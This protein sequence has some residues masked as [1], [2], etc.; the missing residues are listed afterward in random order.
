MN[1]TTYSSPVP[2]QLIPSD[3]RMKM[4][5]YHD[6]FKLY[7]T[8]IYLPDVKLHCNCGCFSG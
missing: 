7:S 8:T 3:T 1:G 6:L 4:L 2:I 5:G